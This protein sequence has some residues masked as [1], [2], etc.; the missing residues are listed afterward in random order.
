ME[1]EPG[2]PRRR[3]FVELRRPIDENPERRRRV[4]DLKR[5]MLDAQQ[6]VG[7]PK[8]LHER[9]SSVKSVTSRSE[10]MSVKQLMTAEDVLE[11]P[12]KPG[13]TFELID[14]E[15]REVPGAGALH[16]LVALMILKLVQG[17]VEQRDLGIVFSDGLG[18]VLR[19]D[20]DQLRIPDVS[21]VAWD[22]VPDDGIPEGFW[23][24]APVLAVEVISPHDR[25][26]DIHDRV[27]DYLDA[28]TRVVWVFWPR[29]TSVTV[30]DRDGQRELGADHQLGGGDA[31]PGFTA[32]VGD[33]F[34]IPRRR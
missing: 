14:G 32:R 4:A 3:S 29:Q 30:Y 11:M 9:V 18:F 12:E 5:A 25:A 22:Q 23:E 6:V 33:L 2:M 10:T 8:S 34:E 27:R 19:R 31:L 7:M 20:P 21:F 15:L 13:F 26:S 24:G 17:F 28:G 1:K 16:N